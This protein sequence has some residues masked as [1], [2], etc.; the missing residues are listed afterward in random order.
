MKVTQAIGNGL[1]TFEM[2]KNDVETIY[3]CVNQNSQLYREIIHTELQRYFNAFK[4][5]TNRNI[6]IA[7]LIKQSGSKR[8][9]PM[10]NLR[11]VDIPLEIDLKG[12]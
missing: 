12:E 3:D 11:D 10:T 2:L 7:D 6:T 8:K 1:I 9:G 4:N 5:N